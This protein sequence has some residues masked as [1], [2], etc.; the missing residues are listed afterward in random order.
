MAHDVFISHSSKDKAVADATCAALEAAGIRC[1]IAPRDI[2]T[3]VEWTES[4]VT[5]IDGAAAALVLVFSANSNASAQ[6]RRE[7]QLAF[8]RDLPVLPLLIEGVKPHN[9]L[10]YYLA[11]VHWLDA[12]TAPLDPHLAQLAASI[13]RLLP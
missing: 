4:I 11:S 8:D 12:R 9:T 2:D 1:W 13:R 3:G 10:R 6:V 5:A 7:V